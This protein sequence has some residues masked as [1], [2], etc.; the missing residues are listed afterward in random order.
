M[1]AE[2]RT[3]RAAHKV[4]DKI[5]TDW[6]KKDAEEK[7]NNDKWTWLLKPKWRNRE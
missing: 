3:Q 6:N 7:D 4:T 1:K 5:L 2:I